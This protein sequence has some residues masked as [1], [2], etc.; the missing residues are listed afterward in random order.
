MRLVDAKNRKRFNIQPQEAIVKLTR[1]LGVS[2]DR[3]QDKIRVISV[4]VKSP[5]ER[6]G[7]STGDYITGV[8]DSS[9]MYMDA[10]A[11]A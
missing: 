8:W 10:Q 9:L 1:Q 3:F 6:A 11:A 5:A 7:I 4:A 2:V